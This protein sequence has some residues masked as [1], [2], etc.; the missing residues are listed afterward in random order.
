MATARVL[1]VVSAILLL[2]SAAMAQC[3]LFEPPVQCNAR[4]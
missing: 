1:V 2:P 3:D 4:N